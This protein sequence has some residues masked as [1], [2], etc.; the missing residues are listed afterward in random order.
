MTRQSNAHNPYLS[1]QYSSLLTTNQPVYQLTSSIAHTQVRKSPEVAKADGVTN[2][3]QEEVQLPTPVATGN[4][5][6]PRRLRLATA[7]SVRVGTLGSHTHN[8][9][10]PINTRQTPRYICL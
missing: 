9:D 6:I 10:T 5:L 1:T 7:L 3:R 8:I 2:T 4:I